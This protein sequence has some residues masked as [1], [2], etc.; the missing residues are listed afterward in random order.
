MDDENLPRGV[1][2]LTH[3]LHSD[4][5]PAPPHGAPQFGSTPHAL[6]GTEFTIGRLAMSVHTG[7]HVDAPSHLIPGGKTLSDYPI[8]RFFGHAVFLDASG[9][10]VVTADHVRA[11]PIPLRAG[12]ALFLSFGRAPL[13]GTE[14]YR[15]AHPHLSEDA[16]ELLAQRRTS[17]LGID[18]PTPELASGVRGDVYDF[19]VHRILLSAD[20]LI[21]E[22]LGPRVAEL[23]GQRRRFC[24]LPL[25]LQNLDGSPVRVAAW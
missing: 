4:L 13:Y 11:M 21:I 17:F 19:P 10:D 25:P 20:C 2:D 14:D 7:T 22:N 23:T 3:T 1:I 8:D 6:A 5:L 18:A 9:L 24:A 15:R 16:A 12:D